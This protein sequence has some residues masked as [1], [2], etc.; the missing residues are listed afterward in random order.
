MRNTPTPRLGCCALLW[1]LCTLAAAS[2]GICAQNVELRELAR[3]GGM[4]T[5]LI[6]DERVNRGL[7]IVAYHDDASA[8][9]GVLRTIY[10]RDAACK[11]RDD[12][13]VAAGGRALDVRVVAVKLAPLAAPAVW[14]LPRRASR[15]AARSS[16]VLLLAFC[17]DDGVLRAATCA[18]EGCA[19]P[20]LGSQ[21]ANNCDL[22]IS[23]LDGEGER[24]PLVAYRGN[25]DSAM[26]RAVFVATCS[27]ALCTQPAGAPVLLAPG[28]Y[29]SIARSPETGLPLVA[30]QLN[31]SA[32]DALV[33]ALVACDSADCAR[34]V[35]LVASLGAPSADTGRYTSLLPPLTGD[36]SE[37]WLLFD[38]DAQS[39]DLTVVTC[40]E[41]PPLRCSAP[42][43]LASAGAATYGE[44]IHASRAPDGNAAVA[45]YR[46]ESARRGVLAV[47]TCTDAAC[48]DAKLETIA[49]GG[50]GFG[51]DSSLAWG[52]RVRQGEPLAYLSFMAY[53]VNASKRATMLAV[54]HKP[55]DASGMPADLTGF[56]D[57][58]DS[59]ELSSSRVES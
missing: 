33:T 53:A 30:M 35:S 18:A 6:V 55:P 10:C 27:D 21:L 28:G 2:V 31:A 43:I 11:A 39:N 36:G 42:R 34:A 4:Y 50:C 16:G 47:S 7:P 51:R 56:A 59:S 40:S 13:V 58:C 48:L 5:R 1:S 26:S 37:P 29:P 9:L 54:L 38:F 44:Y 17:A 20:R 12:Y 25:T 52:T 3:P 24:P 23:L 14:P 49:A 41:G 57:L 15:A 46:Q 45:F 8:Q 19:E 32:D 22:H